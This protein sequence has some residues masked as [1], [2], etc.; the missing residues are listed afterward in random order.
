[1]YSIHSARFLDALYCLH[2][3]VCSVDSVVCSVHAKCFQLC[4]DRVTR[5]KWR[6]LS[7]LPAKFKIA[8]EPGSWIRHFLLVCGYPW[9]LSILNNDLGHQDP[10]G[11]P[12]PSPHQPRALNS[13]QNASLSD[14]SPFTSA[15]LWSRSKKDQ[16]WQQVVFAKTGRPPTLG[17]GEE[18]SIVVS[19]SYYSSFSY[20]SPCSSYVLLS[21]GQLQ[22]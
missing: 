9:Q 11:H 20:F 12:V 18:I 14:L 16:I 21:P 17:H 1:M 6:K 13:S 3:G 22:I 15:I 19:C 10:I 8:L 5:K 4:C 2:C 7:N